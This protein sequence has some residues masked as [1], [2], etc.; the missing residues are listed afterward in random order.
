MCRIV[1]TGPGDSGRLSEATGLCSVAVHRVEDNWSTSAHLKRC[2]LTNSCTYVE[3]TSTINSGITWTWMTPSGGVPIRGRSGV[4]P[5][6]IA[7]NSSNPIPMPPPLSPYGHR[8][9][10]RLPSSSDPPLRL[11]VSS[12]GERLCV[13]HASRSHRLSY[14]ELTKDK[15]G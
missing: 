8:P 12:Q 3:S 6:L 2:S 10:P 14:N 7:V 9:L 5:L 15:P 11:P 1:R 13:G 4:V